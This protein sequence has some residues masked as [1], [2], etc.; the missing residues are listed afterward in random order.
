MSVTKRTLSVSVAAIGL[1]PGGGSPLQLA[2]AFRLSSTEI[3]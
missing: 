3:V 1:L 2:F